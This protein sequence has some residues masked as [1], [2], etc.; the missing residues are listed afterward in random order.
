VV[1]NKRH[2]S[3]QDG[4]TSL[5]EIYM[6]TKEFDPKEAPKKEEVGVEVEV[7]TPERKIK[8]YKSVFISDGVYRNDPVYE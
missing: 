2:Y 5:K 8:E 6:G 4:L 1:S 3:V 7:E